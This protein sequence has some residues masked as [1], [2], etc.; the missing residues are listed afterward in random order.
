[1][2]F[3]EL[4]ILKSKFNLNTVACTRYTDLLKKVQQILRRGKALVF[5]EA[6]I[7]LKSEIKL[8]NYEC[9]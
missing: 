3:I 6:T 4:R 5:N 1:M 7:L 9:E 2:Y 8:S